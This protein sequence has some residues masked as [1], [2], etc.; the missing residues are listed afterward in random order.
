MLIPVTGHCLGCNILAVAHFLVAAEQQHLASI[1]DLETTSQEV[2]YN[3]NKINHLVNYEQLT[4]H[5]LCASQRCEP[6]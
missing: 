2:E 6:C 1:H 5:Q 3:L 4:S